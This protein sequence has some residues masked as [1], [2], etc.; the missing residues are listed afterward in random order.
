MGSVLYRVGDRV[1][2]TYEGCIDSTDEADPH[3]RM[4]AR[5]G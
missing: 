5:A 4:A 3:R 2:V 1:R